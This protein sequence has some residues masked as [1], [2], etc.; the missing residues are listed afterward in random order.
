MPVRSVARRR[1]QCTFYNRLSKISCGSRG[2]A[3]RPVRGRAGEHC[4]A[5]RAAQRNT[6]PP[7]SVGVAVRALLLMCW[8]RNPSRAERRLFDLA[9]PARRPP[10]NCAPPPPHRTHTSKPRRLP[11]VSLD[12]STPREEFP[13]WLPPLQLSTR[14]APARG[15]H[16]SLR[17]GNQPPSVSGAVTSAVSSDLGRHSSLGQSAVA[18]SPVSLPSSL[19]RA[20]CVR[21]GETPRC[22]ETPRSGE[23]PRCGETRASCVRAITSTP[24]LAEVMLLPPFALQKMQ[25]QLQVTIRQRA[26]GMQLDILRVRQD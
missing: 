18:P 13:H 2:S 9:L 25:I 5:P 1:C 15:P 14:T 17:S 8:H 26:R 3:P 4:A 11:Y 10:I 16:A 7:G 6:R 20:S 12:A 19:T 23:T 22:G 21:S 24:H